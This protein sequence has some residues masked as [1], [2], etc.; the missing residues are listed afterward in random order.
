MKRPFVETL[1]WVQL[2]PLSTHIHKKIYSCGEGI[3]FFKLE[4]K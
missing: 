1:H 4:F 3:V 2:N